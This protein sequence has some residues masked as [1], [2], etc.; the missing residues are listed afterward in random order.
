MSFTMSRLARL[1]EERTRLSNQAQELNNR[2]D[3]KTPMP[4][5]VAAQLDTILDSI[6][7]I[8]RDIEAEGQQR[9]RAG[10][11]ENSWSID[12]QA[13]RVLRSREDIRAHFAARSSAAAGRN[14][15][16]SLTEFVRGLAG[17][18]TTDAVRASLSVGTDSAGG[19]L[20]P[21]VLMPAI[22]EA[23][24]PA[25]TV[26]TAG[27]GII[28]LGEGAKTYTQAAIDAIPTA[29]WRAENGNVVESDPTFRAVVATPRS[30]AFFFKISR[31]LL[32]D[33][34]NVESA[35][36][37]AI[38]QAFAKEL[39]RTALRG[40]G[41]A[42]QPR[43]LL[44]TV[45]INAVPNGVNGAS[46][47]STKH[48]NLFAALRAQLEADAPAPAAA[49]MS[50]RSFVTLGGLTDLQEQPLQMP[51]MLQNLKLLATT[52]IPN[53]LTV[54]T[55]SDCSEIYVGDFTRLSFLMREQLSIQKVTEL[56]ATSGQ[57]GFICHVRCDVMVEYAKAF[58]LV[59][60]VR[61]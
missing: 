45:G 12:G 7:A 28:P 20:V 55:S 43:G 44:N 36:R 21:A 22:L 29:A 5:A 24:V 47:S 31:E 39:D 30:L 51:S 46:L 58:T 35:L 61:P 27:A 25:S 14:E 13:V 4:K 19:H 2:Y 37:I 26:L 56:F 60:G 3:A 34:S 40:T 54:G 10:D 59:T 32:A 9:E 52:Q 18:Q 48:A 41:T 11:L 16:I 15:P 49:I 42:P 6:S 38:S 17:M 33:A 53:D 8:D 50:P 23:L 1:R 57:I